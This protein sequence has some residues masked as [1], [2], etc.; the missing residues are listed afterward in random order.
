LLHGDAQEVLESCSGALQKLQT[1]GDEY[2]AVDIQH[3]HI[4]GTVVVDE[5]RGTLVPNVTLQSLVPS[6]TLG[7]SLESLDCPLKTKN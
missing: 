3:V 2:D 7:N 4:V 5:Q 1:R 6:V